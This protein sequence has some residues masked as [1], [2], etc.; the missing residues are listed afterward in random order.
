MRKEGLCINNLSVGRL[1]VSPFYANEV[2][3][4]RIL[5]GSNICNCYQGV[6][7]IKS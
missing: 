2:N 6:I 5:S 4:A 1:N 3:D 7:A